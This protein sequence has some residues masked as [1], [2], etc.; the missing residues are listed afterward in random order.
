V[1][2]VGITPEESMALE[3]FAAEV[4]AGV[5]CASAADQQRVY[6]LLKLTG[7]ATRDE[8]EGVQLG[9]Y[10]ASSFVLDWRAVLALRP[11]SGN[12]LVFRTVRSTFVMKASS[13]TIAAARSGA[14][15]VSTAG[16]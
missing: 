15:S 11:H 13:Q 2:R 4:R 14:T 16:S 7:T 8:A 12:N 1:P 6:R 10:R 5:E 9:R 3:T